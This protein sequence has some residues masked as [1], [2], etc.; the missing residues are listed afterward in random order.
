[1]QPWIDGGHFDKDE[2]T[3]ALKV[4]TISLKIKKK[5]IDIIDDY[6]F[7]NHQVIWKEGE[8]Y[9]LRD[10]LKELLKINSGIINSINETKGMENY[11]SARVS[12]MSDKEIKKICYIITLTEGDN[13]N[14]I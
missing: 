6:I 7:F 11:V 8:I 12:K 13:D 4:V 2:L 10:I 9:E 14:D 5:I 3:D 1:M